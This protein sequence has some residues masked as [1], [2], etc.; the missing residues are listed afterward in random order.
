MKRIIFISVLLIIFCFGK[1]A[2][3]QPHLIITGVYDGPLTGGLPKGV[4]L[5]VIA[6]IS[7]LSAY[8]LGSANNGGG[9]DG[10]E[11]TFPT[12][13]A[14][15]GEYIYVASEVTG[16][17]SWFGSAPNYTAGAMI[18]NGN[19][20]IELF[21]NGSAVDVFGDINTD[22]TGQDWEYLD[23]WAYSKSNRGVSTTF[24]SNHWSF[25]GRNCLDV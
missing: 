3:A 14:T 7:D 5:Y 22:G 8:G 6:D 20:A 12:D 21:Y 9:T 4:E 23:G 16:F 19:D 10:V 24:N 15:A 17:T 18:I 11:Y 1:F 25:S 13:A 2:I